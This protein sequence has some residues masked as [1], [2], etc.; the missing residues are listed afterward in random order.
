MNKLLWRI[1]GFLIKI[2]ASGDINVIINANLDSK[3]GIILGKYNVFKNVN[4]EGFDN[5][6]TVEYNSG[7]TIIDNKNMYYERRN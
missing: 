1:R 2:L 4:I 6:Y 7:K 3:K 5:A